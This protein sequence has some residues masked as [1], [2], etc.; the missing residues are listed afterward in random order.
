MVLKPCQARAEAVWHYFAGV[1]EPYRRG[2]R[3]FSS[4]IGNKVMIS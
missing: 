1:E 3:I 2:V 4:G